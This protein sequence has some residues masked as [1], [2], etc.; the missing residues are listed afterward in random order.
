MLT[1]IEQVSV[2]SPIQLLV[3][4]RLWTI[5]E[6]LWIPAIVGILSCMSTGKFFDD[7]SACM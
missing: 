1:F 4:W 6:S 2:S 5:Q 7:E 3:A